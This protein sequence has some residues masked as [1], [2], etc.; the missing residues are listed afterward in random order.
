MERLAHLTENLNRLANEGAPKEAML[1]ICFD[2]IRQ[3]KHTTKAPQT[4]DVMLP[5][6][7]EAIEPS[8]HPTVSLNDAFHPSSPDLSQRLQQLRHGSLRSSMGINDRYLFLETLFKGDAHAF[9]TLMGLLDEAESYQA[10][11]KIISDYVVAV[12]MGSD[13]S[14]VVEQFQA[15]VKSRF[16]AI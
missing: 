12:P 15:L 7:P 4:V 14:A 16:T 2:I 9:D 6:A 3:L 5:L 11:E 10:C 8:L 1:E 13:Q